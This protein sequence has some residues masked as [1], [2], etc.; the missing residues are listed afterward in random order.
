MKEQ[1]ARRAMLKIAGIIEKFPKTWKGAVITT[2]IVALLSLA[3]L[4][5]TSQPVQNSIARLIDMR[6]LQSRFCPQKFLIE[7]QKLV[8]SLEAKSVVVWATDIS[9]NQASKT[10]MFAYDSDGGEHVTESWVGKSAPLYASERNR[11]DM[12]Y[13]LEGS[14]VCS[15]FES[16]SEVERRIRESDDI[17]YVCSVP[18]PPTSSNMIGVISVYFDKEQTATSAVR[19]DMR[20]ASRNIIC[21]D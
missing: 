15:P 7:S 2:W 13:L 3:T 8:D 9:G 21:D 19:L 10:V 12:T 17:S 11:L 20:Q 14:V 6:D 1:Q 5:T 4:I 16:H 18:V